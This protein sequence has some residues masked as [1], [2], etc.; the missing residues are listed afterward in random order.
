[1]TRIFLGESNRREHQ[2]LPV[3]YLLPA[4][5]SKG[6][7]YLLLLSKAPFIHDLPFL[8]PRSFKNLVSPMQ[9]G[10]GPVLC[11]KAT[12]YFLIRIEMV[13]GRKNVYESIV[14][15]TQPGSSS[16]LTRMHFLVVCG[17]LENLNWSTGN[18]L[19]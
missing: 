19:Q 11:E 4:F 12:N 9:S 16:I 7:F 3:H 1:M 8:A 6:Y 2:M 10:V 17:P 15:S 13:L 5:T 14:G 18:V